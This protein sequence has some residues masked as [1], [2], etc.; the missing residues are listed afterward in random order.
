MS[1]QS[2]FE[3][4]LRD[5]PEVKALQARLSVAW[6]MTDHY[7]RQLDLAQMAFRRVWHKLGVVQSERDVVRAQEKRSSADRDLFIKRARGAASMFWALVDEMHFDYRTSPVWWEARIFTKPEFQG[8][9]GW[10][11]EYITNGRPK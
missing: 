5:Q 6:M 3:Q 10:L 7:R 9:L 4:W 11:K 2:W 8:K 1:D